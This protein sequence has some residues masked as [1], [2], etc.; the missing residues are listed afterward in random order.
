MRKKAEVNNT[1]QKRIDVMDNFL[2]K[3]Q[4]VE[5]NSKWI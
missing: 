5:A 1:E 2:E 3:N 4:I